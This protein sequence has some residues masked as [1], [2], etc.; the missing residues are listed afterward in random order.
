MGKIRHQVKL[1]LWRDLL[2]R[3]RKPLSTCFE[4]IWPLS[5]F[6]VVI[7]V[8]QG[9]MPE[10]QPECYFDP[11]MLPSSGT[12]NFLQ[13]F[14]CKVDNSCKPNNLTYTPDG[15]L[16]DSRL[17]ET[18]SALSM[19]LS[20][21]SGPIIDYLPRTT[22]LMEHVAEV[23][24]RPELQAILDDRVHINDLFRGENT[25]TEVLSSGYSI[26]EPETAQTLLNAR[27]NFSS[28]PEFLNS[29]IDIKKIFCT[30]DL[31]SEYLQVDQNIGIKWVSHTL[32]LMPHAAIPELTSFLQGQVDLE[33][34]YIRVNDIIADSPLGELS[35]VQDTKAIIDVLINLADVVDLQAIAPEMGAIVTWMNNASS[36]AQKLDSQLQQI[37][38]IIE[39]FYNPDP[40]MQDFF[41]NSQLQEATAASVAHVMDLSVIINRINKNSGVEPSFTDT[42]TLMFHQLYRSVDDIAVTLHTAFNMPAEDVNSL[43]AISVSLDH[44]VLLDLYLQNT[45]TTAFHHAHYCDE[46]GLKSIFVAVDPLQQRLVRDLQSSMCI[47]NLTLAG[48]HVHY[49]ES[50]QTLLDLPVHPMEIAASPLVYKEVMS[51]QALDD[52]V[53]F[54]NEINQRINDQQN[55]G[56]NTGGDL[57]F[58]NIL[59]SVRDV[60]G[61]FSSLS[62]TVGKIAEIMDLIL[63]K[64]S[65]EGIGAPVGAPIYAVLQDV[66]LDSSSTAEFITGVLGVA[67]DVTDAIIESFVDVNLLSQV[68]GTRMTLQDVVCDASLLGRFFLIGQT[69]GVD[70]AS[71]SRTLCGTIDSAAAQL[72]VKSINVGAIVQTQLIDRIPAYLLN[73]T[74]WDERVGLIDVVADGVAGAVN[75]ANMVNHLVQGDYNEAVQQLTSAISNSFRHVNELKDLGGLVSSL[76]SLLQDAPVQQ[77]LNDVG[78]VGNAVISLNISEP[79]V[80]F[81]GHLGEFVRE[82]QLVEDYLTYMLGVPA[83]ISQAIMMSNFSLHKVFSISDLAILAIPCN[84]DFLNDWLMLP[85]GNDQMVAQLEEI[86]KLQ[87]DAIFNLTEGLLQELNIGPYLKDYMDLSP[88]YLLNASYLTPGDLND[89]INQLQPLFDDVVELMT[90]VKAIEHPG[91]QANSQDGTIETEIEWNIA[92]VSK[93]LCG[94]SQLGD[95]VAGSGLLQILGDDIEYKHVFT[96][97]HHIEM[98]SFENDFCVDMYKYVQTYQFSG[99]IIWHQIKPL[100]QGRILYTPV[101]D[102]TRNIMQSVQDFI[103]GIKNVKKIAHEWL[104]GM[105]A[106]EIFGG[107]GSSDTAPDTDLSD[108]MKIL[109]HKVISSAVEQLIGRNGDELADEWQGGMPKDAS[110]SEIK[111]MVRVVELLH[112]ITSCFSVH[113]RGYADEEALMATGAELQKNNTLLAGIV[114]ENVNG[115]IDSKHIKYKIRM[116]TDMVR[117]SDRIRSSFYTPGP[118]ANFLENMRYLRGFLPLQDLIEHGIIRHITG[119]DAEVPRIT[120]N[121]MPYPCHSTDN[122]QIYSGFI[123]AILLVFTWLCVF[124]I[125]IGNY[126]GDK[127]AGIAHVMQV[128]G[129]Q[130]NSR[131]I[132]WFIGTM[133]SNIFMSVVVTCCLIFGKLM[134]S[135]DPTVIF[136]VL[137]CYSFSTTMFAY[138]ISVFFRRTT[139]AILVGVLIY[140]CSTMPF[141][142]I[143]NQAYLRDIGV[144]EKTFADMGV[145][146]AMAHVG[147]ELMYMEQMGGYTSWSTMMVPTTSNVPTIYAMMM[148]IVNTVLYGLVGWFFSNVLTGPQGGGQ[149]VWFLFTR[150]YWGL[151][152][153]KKS[154]TH[155]TNFEKKSHYENDPVPGEQEPSDL[156]IGITIHGLTKRFRKMKRPAVN[157]LNVNFYQGQVTAFLGHNG[158]GKTS[159]INML[160][161]SL[162]PSNGVAY[163]NGRDTQTDMMTIREEMGICPQ[164]DILFEHMTVREHLK[165]YTSLKGKSSDEEMKTEVQNM[166]SLIG[167]ESIA[168]DRAENLSGGQRRRLSICA[169]FCGGSRVVLLDEP[170]SGVDPAARRNIWDIIVKHREGRT[171]LL[172]THHLDEAEAIGDRIVIIHKGQL[173]CHG[174]P[175]FLKNYF[176]SGYHLTIA[177]SIEEEDQKA[178]SSDNI[179][180]FIRQYVHNA[181]L[182]EEIGSEMTFVLPHSK[183]RRESLTMLFKNIEAKQNTLKIDKYGISDTPLEEIFLKVTS[184][185]ERDESLIP[186]KIRE[187]DGSMSSRSGSAES[188]PQGSVSRGFSNLG[189]IGKH[190][191]SGSSDDSGSRIDSLPSTSLPPYSSNIN[192]ERTSLSSKFLKRSSPDSETLASSMTASDSGSIGGSSTTDSTK[193]L[194]KPDAYSVRT[195]GSSTKKSVMTGT[196]EAS[197]DQPR[198]HTGDDRAPLK[199][200]TTIEGRQ[201]KIRQFGALL[202]KRV[203]HN[204]RNKRMYFAQ[205]FLPCIFVLCAM[206]GTN[207]RVEFEYESFPM[208]TALYSP[209]AVHILRYNDHSEYAEKLM[210][211]IQESGIG[212]ACVPDADIRIRSKC[213][214]NYSSLLYDSVSQHTAS[215]IRKGKSCNCDNGH[216]T[217]PAGSEGWPAPYHDTRLNDRIYDITHDSDNVEEYVMRTN[218]KYDGFEFRLLGGRNGGWEFDKF[219]GNTTAKVWFMNK[220]W[221]AMP[222]YYNALSNMVLRANLDETEKQHEYGIT[223]YNHPF[224]MQTNQFNVQHL[225]L[226][227]SDTGVVLILMAALCFLP[228]G[229]TTYLVMERKGKEKRLQYICGVTSTLYWCTAFLWD[230]MSYFITSTILVLIIYAYQRPMYVAEE[231]FIALVTLIGLFGWSCIP[232]MYL[233]V[234]WFNDV[235]SSFVILF[236]INLFIGLN[237]T[238][239]TF[240]FSLP[241]FDNLDAI[242]MV[243]NVLTNMFLITP[244]YAI[245][246][247]LLRLARNQLVSE[248]FYLFDMD[249][250]QSPFASNMLFW[251]FITMTIEGF[252]FFALVLLIEAEIICVRT[253]RHNKHS[254]DYKEDSDVSLERQRVMTGDAKKDVLVLYNLTK[255]YRRGLQKVKAVDNLCVGIPKGEC[256]G[257]LGINGAGKTTSFKMITGDVNPSAGAAIMN[258]NI[259]SEDSANM[260]QQVGYCPQFDALDPMLTGSEILQFYARLKGIPA[261]DI[262]GVVKAAIQKFS[263][264]EHASKLTGAYS[265]G[266]RRKLSA[267]VSLL[268]EPQLV[269]MDEPTTGMDPSTR[270]L[271][272]NN[273]LSIVKDNRSVVLTSHSMAECDALCTRM[274]I[275]V[276]GAFMCLGNSQHLKNKFGDGYTAT[277]R[278]GGESTD[279]S[280]V[281]TFMTEDFPGTRVTDRHLRQIEFQVPNSACKLSQLFGSLEDKKR[282]GLVEDYS[283]TQ[284]TLDQVFLHFARNQSDSRMEDDNCIEDNISLV[285]ENT[286]S[287]IHSSISKGKLIRRR[288]L[289]SNM[290][291][292]PASTSGEDGKDASTFD[293]ES[294]Q[295]NHPGKEYK[296]QEDGLNLSP[297]QLEEYLGADICNTNKHRQKDINVNLT[298]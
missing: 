292:Y 256:F 186:E 294:W 95:L 184:L 37:P 267:A 68:I 212:V 262:E 148:M 253:G 112:N 208:D 135:T 182:V 275:M 260:Q 55:A 143:F 110:M 104:N 295:Y 108:I 62:P 244:Q 178:C 220:A 207:V 58:V 97:K 139:I 72:F 99:P 84:F 225:Y 130:A 10:K 240:F 76:G 224:P 39:M 234:R 30:P 79:N 272:W 291:A 188:S 141:M 247:G 241:I 214:G 268:G 287:S 127:E 140:L 65:F 169:A 282:Q 26:V 227:I 57:G 165:F 285:S 51:D 288:K 78:K 239:I 177:K 15:R 86:C 35:S 38:S 123:I 192:S 24:T 81:H 271:V 195:S 151:Q 296:K 206:T 92:S 196:T 31:L 64:D 249:I 194:I 213:T 69:P 20:S 120:L 185:A 155:F 238:A 29:Y 61:S 233:M 189:F 255:V 48:H 229:Y 250:Y 168:D 261:E 2:R 134:I 219:E 129:L 174:S 82:P 246:D 153:K 179:L 111:N 54:L 265:A 91:D 125:S 93:V 223:V 266:N 133:V 264:E 44:M 122:F 90:K 289:I 230:L 109:R 19:F 297:A 199:G 180:E 160:T 5:I 270:R 228:P 183:K 150:A 161:G 236:L 166:L 113:I 106:L 242:T 75:A 171:I 298:T 40:Q 152:S 4:I 45:K 96:E 163:I 71:L 278:A 128:M 60:M 173:Q 74:W 269:L 25:L 53:P 154:N 101:N 198:I 210:S 73:D 211:T 193:G 137:L 277:V 70:L 176:G 197:S 21:A 138:M 205:I 252:V 14:L 121:Q 259:I 119:N 1:L 105:K 98:A 131:W 167:M 273:I 114:F 66:L 87:P 237:S 203:L 102:V 49:N 23:F 17:L 181:R 283:V 59:E 263:L 204:L 107:I 118:E 103:Y 248:V 11:W 217:C 56:R 94:K 274:A 156:P 3:K 12:V 245:G 284:T 280:R 80:I 67:P 149:P 218:H 9:S 190:S 18:Q 157:K 132:A 164:Y 202:M 136:V 170:T 6:M 159:T 146:S 158:A 115:K 43:L 191:R 16:N 100:I 88:A 13:S 231:N 254:L 63:T 290:Q 276:N 279:I 221:H 293:L 258:G 83:P 281:I 46:P 32:C 33:K 41:E 286:V 215:K 8:R 243:K 52:F 126:V 145:G 27:L 226:R 147:I 42:N 28:I 116:D 232:M 77:I 257:L 251:H 50:L 187:W 172:S 85:T 209:D 175:M 117:R 162:R 34:V 222:A 124:A 7:V 144:L 22:G 142:Q 200:S 201:L 89:F 36:T 47:A 235:N 216:N